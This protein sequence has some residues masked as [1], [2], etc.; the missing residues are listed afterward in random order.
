VTKHIVQT[1]QDGETLIGTIAVTSPDDDS[2]IR[3]RFLGTHE[4]EYFDRKTVRALIAALE[5][6]LEQ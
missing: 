6:A 1:C 3:I 4:S 2:D 5:V